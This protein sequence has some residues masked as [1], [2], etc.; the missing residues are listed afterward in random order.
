MFYLAIPYMRK[1]PDTQEHQEK[2]KSKVQG[3]KEQLYNLFTFPF[4]SKKKWQNVP[5]L[6]NETVSLPDS[7]HF[8][9]EQQE[10]KDSCGRC[11]AK[12]VV[13]DIFKKNHIQKSIDE[14]DVVK[15][16]LLPK[17]SLMKKIIGITPKQM[18]AGIQ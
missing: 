12:M 9:I 2:F 3:F 17:L 6:G 8:T 16:L 13:D 5:L 18:K 15:D 11:V 14:K 1:T 4:L 10:T 7:E